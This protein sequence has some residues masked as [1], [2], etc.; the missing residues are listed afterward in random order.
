LQKSSPLGPEGI[1]KEGKP[2]RD[3]TQSSGQSGGE[4]EEENKTAEA[5]LF[6]LDAE[7]SYSIRMRQALVITAR[8]GRA[9]A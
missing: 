7:K 8:G 1:K 6:F 9:D 5:L 4:G 3:E 2:R